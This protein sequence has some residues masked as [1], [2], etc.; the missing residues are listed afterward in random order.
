MP[1]EIKK[2]TCRIRPWNHGG[3]LTYDFVIDDFFF[4]GH[5]IRFG[6]LTKDQAFGSKNSSLAIPSASK[7][8]ANPFDGR[9]SVRRVRA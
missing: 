4:V 8:N 1:N 3:Q 6:H 9:R 2:T 7:Q 5:R